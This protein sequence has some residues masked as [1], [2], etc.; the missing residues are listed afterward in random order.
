MKQFILSFRG[1]SQILETT[2][3]FL[4]AGFIPYIAKRLICTDANINPIILG[5]Y[6]KISCATRD[7]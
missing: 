4:S 1:G 5:P 2:S 3:D 6:I 7:P